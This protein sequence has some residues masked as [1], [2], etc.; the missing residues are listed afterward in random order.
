[1]D[2]SSVHSLSRRG[3]SCISNEDAMSILSLTGTESE[4]SKAVSYQ[5]IAENEY[6]FDPSVYLFEAKIPV[7]MPCSYK[8]LGELVTRKISR[9]VQY[10]S[11]DLSKL[12]TQE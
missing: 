2:A 7:K 5:K 8:P 10:K 11:S 1:M 12:F 6:S 3:G 4:I 9:G